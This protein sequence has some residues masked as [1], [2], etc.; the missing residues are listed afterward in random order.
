LFF[1]VVATVVYEPQGAHRLINMTAG[2]ERSVGYFLLKY[3]PTIQDPPASQNSCFDDLPCNALGY[4]R[5][6]GHYFN[7]SLG[8]PIV[9]RGEITGPIGGY[10]WIITFVNKTVPRKMRFSAP[11][12]D[13]NSKMLI[14]IPYP[15]GTTFNII[16]YADQGCPNKVTTIRCNETFTQVLTIDAVRN[17][18][19]NTYYVDNDGVLTF[20]MAETAMS[21][22]SIPWTLPNYTSPPYKA[23]ELWAIQRFE[24]DGVLLPQRHTANSYVVTAKCPSDG[25][26]FIDTG[27]CTELVGNPAVVNWEYNPEVCPMGYEQKAYDRCCQKIDPSKCYYSD[28]SKN[29]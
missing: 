2:P 19:G 1:F 11:N 13:P 18:A 5:H 4:V 8:F 27:Y 25:S 26:S 17:G 16:A 7:N 29:F 23:E 22:I 12:I 14:S 6:A 24:R 9:S 15:K 10:G 21:Y 20:R 3:D 28:G